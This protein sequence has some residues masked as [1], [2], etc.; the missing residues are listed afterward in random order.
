MIIIARDFSRKFYKSKQWLKVR[1]NVLMRDNYLC[2]VC[3][4]PA[5]EIHHVI[6]LQPDNI[7]DTSIALGEDNLLSVCRDCHFNIHRQDRGIIH[8]EEEYMFDDD[9]YII[10]DTSK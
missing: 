10:K 1:Q 6:H 9:G 8:V 4:Q 7:N 2:R 5:T 3:G